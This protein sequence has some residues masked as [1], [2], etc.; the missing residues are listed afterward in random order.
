M[1][2]TV[3]G[4]PRGNAS[5][6]SSPTEAGGVMTPRANIGPMR[7]GPPQSFRDA[8]DAA[9][10]ASGMYKSSPTSRE[11]SQTRGRALTAS[12]RS[13]AS[14]S[15]T[16]AAK[17]ASSNSSP[18]R[19]FHSLE[20]KPSGSYAHNRNTSI[21]HGIQHSRNT[22]YVNSP[23]T[24]PLSPHIIAAAAGATIDGAVMSQESIA[25]AFAANGM[26]PGAGAGSVTGNVYGLAG[27]QAAASDGSITQRRPE[28]APSSRSSRKGHNHHRSQ[29]RHPPHPHELKTVGEYA[30]HHL[31]NAFI[32]QAEHKINQCMTERGQPEV[33]VEAVCGPGVD[34]TFDQLI[35]ALGHIARHKPKPLI[36]TI[37]LWRKAKSEEASK[38]RTQ[39]LNARQASPIAHPHPSL[40]RRNTESTQQPDSQSANS[41]APGPDYIIA[42]QQTVTQAEQRSTVSTYLLCRVLIEIMTQTDLKNLTLEMAERLLGLFYGQLSTVDPDLVDISP[43]N[44]ANW[45]IY[46]QLLGVLSGLIFKE[47]QERFV[48]DLKVVDGHLS[49]KNQYNRD[50]EAKGALL[51]RAL[52]HLKVDSYPEESWDQ[53]CDFMLSMAKLFTS[54]HGQ[55]VKY[56]YCQVL[57]ELLLRIASKATVELDAPKWKTVIE[58]M[59]QRAAILIGKPKHWQEAF[60]LM[61]AI[62]CASPTDVFLSQWLA[63]VLSTQ[64]RLKERATRAI[65]LRGICRLVWTY[66]YRRGTEAPNIAVRRLDEIIRMVFLPGRRSY[67]STESAI[68]EPLIQLTRI[69]GYK[70][71]DLC[72]K[73]IIFPLLN[74]EMFT[75]GREL[76]VENLEPDRMVIG[77]RSFLAIMADLENTEQPPFPLTFEYDPNAVFSELPALPSSPRPMHPLPIKSTLLKE[78]RLSRPVNFTGFAEVAKEYYN[79]FCKILGEITIICDNAFGGQAVLDEK[80]SLQTPKTPMADAFSFGRREDYLTTTDPRQ[81]FYDLL[82]VAV[83]ALPRCLSPHIPI[84]ALVN[85]LCTGT[86]H[87][88]SNIAM[89]SAQ[90][91]KS[92]ARQSYAQT[93]TIGFA[94]FIFNFDD[95]YATMSDGGMLGAGHIENTLK[96]Y[97]ELLQIWIEEIK[98][99]TRKAALDT[100]DDGSGNRAA[101]L[102]LSSV[103]AHVDEVESHGLF[104]LCSPSRRVR[105]YAVTVLRLVTEF[106]TALGGSSTRIIRVMEGSPQR[107]LDI[108]DEKLS[109]AE[110]SR[111]QRGM[112]K[113]NR[114]PLR[115][116]LWFKIF[117]N[118]IRISFEVCPFAS[119][120]TRDI[121]CARL[122]Q[123][124]RTLS[125]LSEGQRS[126]PYSPYE[127]SGSKP[128]GRLASTA[129]EVIIEQWKLYLIFAFTTLTSLG[130]TAAS[131]TQGQ[132][133]RKSSK[134][135]QTSTN[136]LHTATELFAKVL[137][138]L[139]V[140][141]VAIRDA[142]VIGLGSVNLNLYRTL[143]ESLQGI[144][145]ACAEE[146]KTRMGNH[147]RTISSPRPM[148]FRTDHLRTEITHD[149]RIFLSDTEVQLEVR[150]LKLR[151][152]YCGLVEV[153]FEGINKTSDPLRWMPF[154]A[155][156]AAFTL[157][158]EWCGYSANQAQIRQR[159]EH[160]RRS[161]LDRAI[162]ADNKGNVTAA[163]EIEKRDL[164]TA[165]LSAMAALCGGPVSITTDSK[166][167][168]QFDVSRMLS[169][170][171]SIFETPS[172]RTHAI[173]RRALSN[174]ILH[175][176]EHPYLLDKAIEMCY[177]AVNS[178][179]LDS[180]FEVVAQVLTQHEDYTLP[181]WKVLSAGLYTLGH[182]NSEIRMK[183]ARL[184]RTLEAREGKNSKLQDLDISIS[185]KTVAVY[186]LAQ[187]ET[188]RR[189]AKQHSE[190]AFLVFSQFSFYFKELQ[191]DHKRNMVAAMLPWVQSVELQVNPDGGPTGNSYMLLVNL[192]EITYT[193]G[194]ALHNEI[195]ALWQALATG[196]YGGNVQLILNFIIS[197]CLDK[198]E[199]NY[200]DYSKQ[201]VVHLSSTP[202]G[203]KVIEFLLLQIN[204][205]S[206][207]S[208]KREPMPP[209]PDAA[210]L[211]YLVDLTTVLPSSNKQSG[212]AL[213]QVCL[214]ML[215]DLMVSPVELAKEH[216]PLLLQ[217]VLVLWDHY[218]A[219]V[220]DQARE[221]LVHLIHELVISK[222][223]DD[224]PGI[225]KR[226]IEDFVEGIRQRDSKVVW[227]YDDKNGKDTADSTTKVPEPMEY[228]AAEVMKFFSFAYPGLREA[229][230]RVALHWATSC[231]VRHI[232]CRSFQLFRCILSSLDQQMLSDMLA[233]LSNTIS[234]EESDIQTFSMEILTTL[235]TI[236][237]ALAPED[238]IQYPQLFWTTCACLDTIHEGEFMESLLMLDKFLDKLDL[239][240]EDV[241]TTLEESCPDKWEGKFEGLAQ[242]TYK[243]IRSSIC[244]DRSL[245]ILER[246]VVLPSSRIVGDDSRL[247]YTILAN[248]PRFLRS[249]DPTV[250]DPS[251]RATAE[252]LAQV[253]EQYYQCTPLAEALTAIAMKRYR[254]EKDFLA[255]IMSTIR[256]AFSPENEFGSLVFLL[257]LLMN[258]IDWMKINTMEV[259][260]V[261]LPEIDMRRPD[262]A[263]KGSDLFSP[264]LR[265]LQTAYCPQALR[266]LDYVI[267]LNMTS[268]LTPFDKQHIR[269]SMAGSH[270]TRGYKKQFEK[271]QSLYGIP[272]DSGWSIPIP[273]LHSQLTRANVHAVFYTCG[274]YGDLHASENETPKVEFRQEEFPFSPL[275]DYHRT[276]TMTSED[277]RGDSHIGE[278]VMKLDSLDDFFEDDDDAETLT[279]LP[280]FSSSGRYM[281]SPYS[282]DMRENLYDQQTAPIL[283]KSLTRNAS[284]TSFQSGFISDVKLSPARDP[285]VMTP[286]AFSSFAGPSSTSGLSTT[287]NSSRPGLHARSATSPSAPNQQQRISPSLTSTAL[288]EQGETFSDD[289]Y[290]TGRSNSTDKSGTFNL[291]NIIKPVAHDTRSRFRSG[292]RRLT[293]GGGDNKEGAK[294]RDAIKLALQKSPQ[295]PKVPDIYLVNPKSADL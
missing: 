121:V 186:K 235:R 120:L 116:T 3:G 68:A 26:Q 149:L 2:G 125:S 271:T 136:K 289:E 240:D 4:R 158:E 94:R 190:L 247:M 180:Y 187:F 216:I 10:E 293:G 93:V 150:Y 37:M 169:W 130:P 167:L 80:F 152:H 202:A 291:E 84:N 264:L 275:S 31:F 132:H 207:V 211:P 250:K 122:S 88:Q 155:R 57:R 141:N 277:T 36:D 253:A 33:R 118:L 92:I 192:F 59:K 109:L 248:L 242:L 162:E 112:R 205:R 256:T 198:R 99:K 144:V 124:Y 172:D 72:F 138:F 219:V 195:Q 100:P 200:V 40:S 32:S 175:N 76:R 258:K 239:G 146:A 101:Q 113:S 197:L 188:S 203:L 148:N 174:L 83:Q 218:T 65:A 147:N 44:L 111:L 234:D 90:S 86:A 209:P 70:Y 18:D 95:R 106:D 85:L 75:S 134:S 278:L 265:L 47:V 69:I 283:N 127:P 236:I 232:A 105:S 233:R 270:S 45:T 78:E 7:L 24:S 279:D 154:Q 166:V 292:M 63:L 114:C 267:N 60:P 284:V 230:G 64:P 133:S 153:L 135:S 210:N 55:P 274:H 143:L 66:I 176:R 181:F 139:S 294:T 228:V 199:Q 97:V 71:Q 126:T 29:S 269:M 28:R 191:P 286:G 61:A 52:R 140:D 226:S 82:H 237:E 179:A 15:Q 241:L 266:V 16:P 67:L 280:N 23:A 104:F 215:V 254:H 142:A 168:L 107:V 48:A 156:K 161:I 261:L 281:N 46:S 257:G 225:D 262:M 255:Q 224:T 6:A 244:L 220:Q 288:E 8:E 208:E 165:A 227:S 79:R 159:E 77:I 56:A 129:P 87:V 184:L 164:R 1:S 17:G 21:V 5:D 252:V 163:L 212:F 249:F 137:P 243:G 282:H 9:R 272:E 39:L 295:V 145:A 287:S 131:A 160:M 103:W 50:H 115:R 49:I 276:A 119:T 34:P 238:L 19:T 285:G 194:N 221:M 43:L 290:A 229:W 110:R 204:P 213:G 25:D 189:L 42:L 27:A 58:M 53:T 11:P 206:M 51:I 12:S 151:T 273:A 217:V 41:M 268:T 22:S 171:Q 102:D 74:S 222:I 108:S 185:D 170:I 30:L 157:M 73:T 182:E 177:L 38:Q 35:A 251:I 223:E 201:I 89:S 173:G 13:I 178:K 259:L 183:S 14:R 260:C 98:R 62:L 196:P 123:M 214:I 245:R 193:S 128:S 91:L 246:L 81:G 117:P 96:L 54:A 20:R 231:P 263:A